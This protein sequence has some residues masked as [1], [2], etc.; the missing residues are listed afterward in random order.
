[1]IAQCYEWKGDTDSAI[2][3]ANKLLVI[4]P[5]NLDALLLAARYWQHQGDE[6]RTYHYANRA[7]QNPPGELPPIPKFVYWI[8][9][10]LSIFPR[11]RRLRE[12]SAASLKNAEKKDRER[13][14]WAV[15]YK[16]WYEAKHGGKTDKVVH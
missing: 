4:D 13:F 11:F 10:S 16:E 1:M 6:E 8:V 12:A 7:A 9:K 5:G 3:Y 15:K 2:E 14:E